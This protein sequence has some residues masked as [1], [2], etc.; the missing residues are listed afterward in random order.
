MEARRREAERMEQQLAEF[1]ATQI[2]RRLGLTL[3]GVLFEFHKASLKHLP[4]A[5][6]LPAL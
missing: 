6:F 5:K 3:S 4:V 1:K 2:E